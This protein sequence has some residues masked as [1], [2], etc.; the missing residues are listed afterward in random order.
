MKAQ[1]GS[2]KPSALKAWVRA[3][4]LTT[5]I[6]KNPAVTLPVVIETL[7]ERFGDALALADDNQRMSYRGLAERSRQYSRWGLRQGLESGDVICLMM[8][9]SAEY[10][11]T[12]VGLTRIGVIVALINTNL[13]GDALVHAIKCVGPRHVIVGAEFAETYTAI[14]TRIGAEV[15]AWMDGEAADGSRRIDQ[16]L[17]GEVGA[18]IEEAEYRRPTI[19]DRALYIYTSGTTGL[20]KAAIV[21]HFQL[22][23][24]S[25]WFAG[26]MD[27][28]AS[29]RM[30]DCLP[31]YHSVGGVVAIGAV[32]VNGGSVVIRPKFSASRFWDEIAEWDCTLFQYIGEL[33]RYLVNAPGNPRETGH[34]IRLGCG[35]GL[36]ADV[37]EEFQRRFAIPQM[38]E[39]YASTEGNV[40]LYNCEG[41]PGA[42]GRVPGFLA[43]RS[44]VALV[45]F[46]Y[47]AQAPW[48]SDEGLCARCAPSE[49]GEAIGKIFGDEGEEVSRFEGY[50]DQEASEKKVLRNVFA[51]GDAWFRTGD[52]MRK[53]EQG[54]YYFADRVGDTFRWKGENVATLEVATK[55][56]EYSGVLDAIVYGVDIPG[57]EGKAG[58]AAI[59]VSDGFDLAAFRQHLVTSLP[60]YARPLFLRICCAIATTATFKAKTQEMAREGYAPAIGDPV[61]F[62]DRS[63]QAFVKLDDELYGRLR[64]G[65]IR[66]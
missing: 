23:Q 62:N 58:M 40:S 20:P 13:A 7:A 48:R 46:D 39:F 41:K 45:K 44:N 51:A 12:W 30:L 25:Y 56:A 1:S 63:R 64:A 24:W 28:R 29:D 26:L 32:L 6:A 34:R 66:V 17:E 59:V 33:C 49:I 16:A 14:R 21:S 36:R 37:W 15:E 47:E 65:E 35:N 38:L 61:F 55:I 9:N 54:Y 60:E 11:A 5:P 22:M 2:G 50:A 52:L 18:V 4:E 27:T 8:A 43:H 57:N 10:F 53:D 31:M 42:I 3:L 19:A